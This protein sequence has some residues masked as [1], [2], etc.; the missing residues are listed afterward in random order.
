MANLEDMIEEILLNLEGYIGSQDVYG[1]LAADITA[2]ATTL[3]LLGGV[4]PDGSG[5]K[6]GII[7]IGTELVYV[8]EF[9]P[10]TGVATGVL[11]GFRGTTA[12][13]QLA[14]TGVRNNPRFPRITIMRAINDT[15]KAL[16]PRIYSVKKTELTI[17]GAVHQYDL[18]A[19]AIN[20]LSVQVK[21]PGASK[22]WVNSRRWSFDNQAGSNSVTGKT[23]NIFDALVGYPAQIVYVAEPST[24]NI[25]EDFAATTNL[26]EWVKEI[27]IYGACWRLASFIDS[28]RVSAI[29]VEQSMMATNGSQITSGTSLAKY[30]LAMFNQRL[31][32]GESRMKLEYPAQKHYIR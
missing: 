9:N 18:P 21:T 8:Q 25:G 15:I 31:V 27:V 5:F 16:Y 17:N 7:E 19:D 11:R 29:S 1:T 14:G 30:F 20:V 32:E 23:I 26:P 22:I 6:T 2:N 28:A 24:L 3:T 10:T 4:Y 13:A 12:V